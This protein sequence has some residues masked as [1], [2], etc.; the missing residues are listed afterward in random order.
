MTGQLVIN[1][2]TGLSAT[3]ANACALVIGGAQTA[4]HIEI[5]PN[6]IQAK[7][8]GTTATT[9]YLNNGGYFSS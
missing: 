1:K 2:N 6:E 5:D 3:A 8:N 9:L 7:S 4:A